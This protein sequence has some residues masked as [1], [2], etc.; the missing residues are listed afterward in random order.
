MA[1]SVDI[2]VVGAVRIAGGADLKHGTA[3]VDNTAVVLDA[4]RRAFAT[5]KASR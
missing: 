3:I 1:F 5:F 2:A 4:K